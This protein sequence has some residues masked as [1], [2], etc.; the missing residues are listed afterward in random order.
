MK[1]VVRIRVEEPSQVGEARRLAVAL[2]RALN[3]Q[4]IDIGKIAL[5]VTE[6]GTNLVKHGEKGEIILRSLECLQINGMEIL[7]LDQG[8]GIPDVPMS[9]QD[10]FSTRGSLGIGLGAIQRNASFFDLYSLEGKGTVICTRFWADEAADTPPYRPLEVGAI[11][12]PKEEEEVCGDGWAVHQTPD[13][14]LCIV[15]D[16]LGHG[17]GAAEAA[18]LAIEHFRNHASRQPGEILSLIHEG[19]RKTR[20]AAVVL[21]EI[22]RSTGLLRFAGVGNISTRVA[23]PDGVRS[24]L[25]HNG[26]VGGPSFKSEEF[27][28]PWNPEDVLIL[29]T[30]GL[31]S[32]FDLDQYPGLLH[33]HPSTI[34]AVLFRDYNRNMDDSTIL[35]AKE[36]RKHP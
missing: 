17:E 16:G 3:F 19:L 30:D 22:D 2:A 7:A 15:A 34:A 9:L 31:K 14:F 32:R 1:D 11:Q 5:Q 6:L 4:E 10:G 36:R 21:A 28:C 35:V 23:T 26:I 24:F 27:T 33:H 25:S 13:R 8:P 20:G 12:F 18:L 29:S